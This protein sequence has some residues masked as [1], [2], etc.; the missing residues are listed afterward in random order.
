MPMKKIILAALL[1]T[2]S[3]A[4]WGQH[5][6]LD[7]SD[8]TL[9]TAEGDI[10]K[11]GIPDLV[12]AAPKALEGS[13]FAFFFGDGQGGYNLFRDY[14]L[15]LYGRETGISIT[16]AGVVR[17]QCD[18]DKGADIFLFRFEKG[19]FRLIGGKKDRHVS[20]HYD[21][22]YNYLTGK[23]IRTD[24]EGKGRKSETTA[25]PA[26]PRINFG[27]IPLHY[28]ALGYLLGEP[29]DDPRDPESMLMMGIFRRMQDEEMLFWHFCDWENPYRDPEGG[30]DG[31]WGASD[32][33]MSPGSYNAWST[34]AISKSQDGSYL[35][36]L[37]E[38]FYDRSYESLFDED[39]SNVDEIME[40]YETE[41]Q[42]SETTWI[43]RDGQFTLVSFKQSP[44]PV[45]VPEGSEGIAFEAYKLIC[46]AE[47]GVEVGGECPE[48]CVLSYTISTDDIE[49]YYEQ[50]TYVCFPLSE[51]GWLMVEAWAGAAESEPTGHYYKSYLFQNGK[52]TKAPDILPVP[53]FARLFNEDAVA[54]GN[55]EAA[56]RLKTVYGERPRD[57]LSYH[58]D[59]DAQTVTVELRP[60]DPYDEQQ[61]GAW[62]ECY[63][64]DR[65]QGDDLPVYRWNGERFVK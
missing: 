28:D 36:N 24:G 41:E 61:S 45:P 35:L 39:F 51:G 34:L 1:G 4:A 62:L 32:D 50:T 20:D 7:R 33:Y 54:P 40:L 29:D 19:D 3:L 17:I 8:K 5:K 9:V 52:M 22:S 48:D 49:G 60:C 26:Q 37:T 44:G 63:W 30:E 65:R 56:A 25:M 57:F 18:L 23:M 14:E 11:D 10:N 46:K 27:W 2:L 47:D 12:V 43:F 38:S 16:D 21:E 15:S 13:T 31:L 64:E 53:P 58:F 6:L 42:I 55:A 59:T